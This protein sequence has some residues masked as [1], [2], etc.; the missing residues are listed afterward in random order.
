MK[1]ILDGVAVGTT[2][3]AIAHDLVVAKTDEII[4][5]PMKLTLYWGAL[6]CHHTPTGEPEEVL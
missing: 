2:E 1:S 4:H 3:R 5:K 6:Y